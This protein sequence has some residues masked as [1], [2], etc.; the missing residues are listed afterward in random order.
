MDPQELAA[1]SIGRL[2]GRQY[3][4]RGGSNWFPCG[5]SGPEGQWLFSPMLQH[6]KPE[7]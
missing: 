7:S 2:E 1:L 5:K 6:G 3:G 4:K